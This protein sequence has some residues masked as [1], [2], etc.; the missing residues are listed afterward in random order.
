LFASH[1]ERSALMGNEIERLSNAE[2][3]VALLQRSSSRTEPTRSDRYNALARQLES[4]H[5]R[6]TA[7]PISLIDG[8]SGLPAKSSHCNTE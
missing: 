8:W 6:L 5:T 4:I 7:E 2:L 1:F 3:L